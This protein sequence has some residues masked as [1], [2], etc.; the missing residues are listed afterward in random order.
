M[1]K[2]L[3]PLALVLAL[4]SGAQ[5]QVANPDP[6][7]VQSGA[8]K[9]EPGHTRVL[10]SLS[11]LGFTTY[12]GEF[13]GASGQLNLD[14]AHPDRSRL[15][16]TVPVAGVW[17]PSAKLNEELVSADW[18]GAA[19]NPNIAFHSTA[20]RRT[21]PRTAEVVGDLTLHG[22]TK[23]VTLKATFN[24]AGVNPLSKAYTTGFEVSG[25][26]KRSDFGVSKYVPLV[27]DEVTLTISAAFERAPT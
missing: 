7:A 12:Y 10:F 19:A 2:T 23:P 26:I 22:V 18:L 1:L 9:I 15:D 25:L 27:G 14:A 8:Y 20:I 3:A 6:A 16:V 4:A 21:G 5:A 24:A 13:P 11:H 17:T